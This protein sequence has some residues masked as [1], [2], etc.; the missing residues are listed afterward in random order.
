M[1]RTEWPS[2]RPSSQIGYQSRS[3]TSA[4][5]ALAPVEQE[6]VEVGRRGEV[7]AAV[8]AD[9]HQGEVVRAPAPVGGRGEAVDQPG[10]DRSPPGIG[11][12]T[13]PQGRRPPAAGL[14]RLPAVMWAVSA[15]RGS[16]GVGVPA[17]RCGCG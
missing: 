10:V 13:A 1:V 17:R 16:D 11:E 5:G 4:G 6:E 8:A 12:R 15:S 7:A 3:A 14:D 2:F 9:G